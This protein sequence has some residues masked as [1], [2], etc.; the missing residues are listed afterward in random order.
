MTASSSLEELP[1]LDG[2]FNLRDL[3]GVPTADGSIR[4]GLVFR[5]D[6]LHRCP[7]DQ[8]AGLR[9]LGI[10][11]MVDLR[12]EAE[13]QREGVFELAGIERAHVPIIED[14]RA[15]LGD[16][17][18]AGGSGP[19]APVNLAG[20]Y[21]AMAR[22][23]GP[24]LGLALETVAD[25]ATAGR[26]VVFHCTAGKDRTGI[27]A[28]VLL[29]GIGVAPKDI[30]ADYARSAPAMPEMVAWYRANQGGSPEDRMREM[31]MDASM[32]QLMLGAEPES[33]LQF[34]AEVETE[35]GSYGRFL[36]SIGGASAIARLAHALR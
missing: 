14:L 23:N 17:D 3:G 36:S 28:A 26:P 5:A 9:E 21:L 1:T 33:I 30:A 31:G 10:E 19:S 18:A 12:T 11:V 29:R 16:H 15:I 4:P 32:A 25:A 20:H 13:R 6:G 2:V 34:L 22:A 35:H 27:V 7:P 8:R 24:G